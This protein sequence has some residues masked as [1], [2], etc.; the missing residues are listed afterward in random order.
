MTLMTISNSSSVTDRD[1]FIVIN[2]LIY[3]YIM[4]IAVYYTMIIYTDDIMAGK[5]AS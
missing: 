5:L 2:G 4:I 1:S 3:K